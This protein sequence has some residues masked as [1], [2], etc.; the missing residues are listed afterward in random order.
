MYKNSIQRFREIVK[1]LA[2]YGFGYIV[3]SKLN[4]ENKSPENLRKAFE[5]LGPSFIKIG[6]I[7]STRPDIISPEYIRELSKLQDNVSAEDFKD[8]S[9][10]FFN[11]FLQTIDET[12]LYFEEEPF[13]SASIAQVHNAILKDG[14]S[15][16]VKIQRP[17]IAEKMKMD[18]SILQRIVKLTKN[19]FGDALIDPEEALNELL[20]STELELN[21]KNE[22]DNI[23]AFKLLNS[24]VNCIYAP[25]VIWEVSSNKVLTLEKINGFKIDDIAKLNENGYDLDDLAQKLALSYLK[26]V[27]DDGFFH[28]DP[29]P[30]NILIREGKI[31]FIDFGIVGKLSKALRES[32]NEALVAAAFKD[33]N[34]LISVLFSIGIKKGP[35]DKN[36]LYEDI[37]YLLDSYLS[38]SLENIK[39]SVMLQE[40]FD[41][42]KHNNL[43]LPKELTLLI[44]SL[45]ILE[46]VI[47]GISPEIKI[48]D[49]ALPYVKANIKNSMLDN[50]SVEDLLF[51]SVK[52]A[53]DSAKIPGKIIELSDSMLSGRARV[54]FELKHLN[55]SINELN[56]MVNRLVFGFIVAAT[57][58]SASLILNTNL[59][60]K[61]FGISIIGI[62]SFLLAAF[63]G[64]WLLISIIKSGKM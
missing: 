59:G 39:I 1:I 10:V 14:R 38:T 53:K 28:G 51:N 29:H 12:F 19:K 26:Q 60:P 22:A 24:N 52:F 62:L 30:G 23:K 47:A 42:S 64:L 43:A 21:F 58:V 8:I 35:I 16:I 49:V 15:V 34:M 5:E 20:N 13:A 55:K 27:L 4:K 33:T 54:Q 9:T 36:K 56:K 7:L 50:I 31:C 11:E 17:D 37:E 41:I 63:A 46:G 40:I 57:I 18:I 61:V 32:L 48:I 45:V 44:R 6:Q 25:D 3:D 2:S